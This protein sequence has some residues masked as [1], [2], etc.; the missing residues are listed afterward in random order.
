MRLGGDVVADVTHRR[1][2]IVNAAN[3]RA[4]GRGGEQRL[5]PACDK[6]TH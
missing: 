5:L 6:W 1:L 2:A 4:D 3:A